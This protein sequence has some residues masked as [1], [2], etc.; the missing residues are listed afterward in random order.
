MV[1]GIGAR[2]LGGVIMAGGLAR[3]MGGGD[4]CLLTLAGRP[5]LSRIIERVQPQVSSLVLNA[6]GDAER[7]AAF[8]L[9]VAPDVLEGR[10]G[11]L[12]GVLTGMEWVAAQDPACEWLLSV[13]GDAPF[14]P[15]DLAERLMAAVQ[16][17]GADMACASSLGRSHPVVGLWPLRLR[18]DLRAAM[19][20]EGLRKVDLWTGRYKLAEVDFAPLESEAGPLDPFFNANR[21]EDL[22]AAE[23]FLCG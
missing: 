20:E 18:G 11:P 19:T 21:P 7:F 16:A 12:A 23:R 22:E 1:E 5:I 13:P 15:C 3:R 6:N 17:Q 2:R 10:P 9:P 14:V 8:G 4:K